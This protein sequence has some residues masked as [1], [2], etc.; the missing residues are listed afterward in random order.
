MPVPVAPEK[1]LLNESVKIGWLHGT[2]NN[3][4]KEVRSDL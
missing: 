1:V 2:P 3:L 4:R